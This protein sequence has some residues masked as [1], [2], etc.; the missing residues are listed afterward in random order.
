MNTKKYFLAALC[1]ALSLGVAVAAE[2]PAKP[3]SI[4]WVG[5]SLFYYNNSMHNHLGK[6]L[7]GALPAETRKGIRNTSVTISGG[8]LGWHNVDFYLTPGVIGATVGEN[9]E[10][11]EAPDR[12]FDIV[13][14]A[15]CTIC[16]VDP[17]TRDEFHA[18]VRKHS[19]SARKHGVQPALFM[20]WA[21]SDKP[22]MTPILAAEYSKAGRDNDAVVVPAGLAF[23]R[24]LAGRPDLRLVV[25]DRR[26]PTVAGSYLG[27][28]VI[29]ATLYGINPVGNKARSGLSDVDAAYLQQVAWDTVTEFRAQGAGR[30]R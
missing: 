11:T 18:M 1:A 12:G 8:R 17:R 5:N 21:Y 2:A 9:N 27:A 22:E 28:A 7:A 10:L 26:H 14:M 23:A 4:L 29:L 6:L 19:E 16:P 20:T 15:D 24:A 13:L 3:P 25:D 30:G